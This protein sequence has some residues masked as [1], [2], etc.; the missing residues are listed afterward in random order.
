[1][2]GWKV[3]KYKVAFIVILSYVCIKDLISD[4]S[5]LELLAFLF[6]AM[7]VLLVWAVVSEDDDDPR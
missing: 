6:V 1:M 5:Y 7:F 2:E 4:D 3:S